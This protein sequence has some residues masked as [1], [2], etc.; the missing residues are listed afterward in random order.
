MKVQHFCSGLYGQHKV[1]GTIISTVWLRDLILFLDGSQTV[2]GLKKRPVKGL[3]TSDPF[4]NNLFRQTYD[5]RLSL[6]AQIEPVRD[7]VIDVNMDKTLKKPIHHYSKT[8]PAME[9]LLNSIL[10]QVVD[11]ASVI[12]PSRPCS[13]KFDPNNISATFKQFEDNRIILS[14]RL[15]E[16]NAI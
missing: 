3:I 8:P 6:N 13:R 1:P 2:T 10:I 9:L 15:G 14:R 11:S 7:L 4:L 12:F 16:K 5:Q